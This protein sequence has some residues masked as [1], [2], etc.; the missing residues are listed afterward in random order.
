MA[1]VVDFGK[2]VL[3]STSGSIGISILPSPQQTLLCQFGLFVPSSGQAQ[4]QGTLGIQSTQG[5]PN[6][7]VTLVRNNTQIFTVDTSLAA[8]NAYDDT[9]FS[10]VDSNVAQGY[11]SYALLVTVLGTPGANTASVIGPVSFSG[12]S[13]M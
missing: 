4:I 5:S 13:F 11:Y 2:S 12:I 6:V 10:Y 9:N 7:Q 1:T 3:A 8:L